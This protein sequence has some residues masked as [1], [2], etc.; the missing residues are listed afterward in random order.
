[1]PGVR[2]YPCYDH[3][4]SEKSPMRPAQRFVP[5]SWATARSRGTTGLTSPPI[6]FACF[7]DWRCLSKPNA[8]EYDSETEPIQ[9]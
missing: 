8:V 7:V 2:A 3:R 5:L 1:M 6:A 4:S 9:C